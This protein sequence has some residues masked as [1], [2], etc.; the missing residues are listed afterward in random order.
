MWTRVFKY[1]DHLNRQKSDGDSN[2]NSDRRRRRI[3]RRN[4]Q[5]RRNTQNSI[6]KHVFWVNE[7]FDYG[8][9]IWKTMAKDYKS[10]GRLNL[11]VSR[12]SCFFLDRFDIYIM[13]LRYWFNKIARLKLAEVHVTPWKIGNEFGNERYLH[14]HW[15][16]DMA[17]TDCTCRNKFAK[18]IINIITLSNVGIPISK[19]AKKSSCAA[20]HLRRYFFVLNDIISFE[21]DL[22]ECIQRGCQFLVFFLFRCIPMQANKN[23]W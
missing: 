5:K 8:N 13:H 17:C 19:I 15:A 6:F 21:N 1:C 23:P 9:A 22:I 7:H 18:F 14:G 12:S 20:V 2:I 3:D 10:I 16:L 4:K 11:E